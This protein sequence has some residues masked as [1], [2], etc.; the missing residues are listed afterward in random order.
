MKKELLTT[1]ALLCGMGGQMAFAQTDVTAQYLQNPGFEGTYEVQSNPSADRAIYQPEGWTVALENVDGYDMSILTTADLASDSF[2]AFTVNDEATRGNQTYW[3]RY[4]WGSNQTLKV[5][6][7]IANLPAGV[8]RLTADVLNYSADYNYTVMLYAGEHAQTRATISTEK[9]DNWS[10]LTCDFYVENDGTI[11]LGLSATNPSAAERIFAVD[12]F[13]LYKL[14]AEAPNA[15]N[16][17]SMTGYIVNPCFNAN[18]DGW[19]STTG[20]QNRGRATNKTNGIITGGFYENWNPNAYSGTIE[21]TINNLPN[22]KYT[23][24]LAAFRSGSA[25]G[26]EAY[27]FANDDMTLI[28]SDEG[29][30]YEVN[31]T[32]VDGTLTFGLKSVNGGC[33]WG[34]VD[35]A[36]LIYHG[37]DLTALVEKLAGVREAATTLKESESVM[38]S[39]C[40][41]ALEDALAATENVAEGE[42][43]LFTAISTVS[44]AIDAANTSIASNA[45]FA[46]GTVASDALTNWTY[47]ADNTFQV[48]TWSVEGNTD[49]SNMTTPFLQIWRSAGTNLT[50][51]SVFYTLEGMEPGLEYTATALVRVLNEGGMATTGLTMFANENKQVIEGGEACDK[52]FYNTYSVSGVVGEDGVLKFGFEIA[53]ATFNWIAFKDIKIAAKVVETVYDL[54]PTE[55]TPAPETSI[56]EL[57]EIV[58]TFPEKIADIVYD[59]LEEC[60]LRN[61]ITGEVYGLMPNTSFADLHQIGFFAFN[62]SYLPITETGTYVLTVPAGIFGDADCI[63]GNGGHGNS[64]LTYTF[65]VEAPV[66]PV[67]AT[68]LPA[69]GEVTSLEQFV[70]DFDRDVN[71]N[72]NCSETIDLVDSEGDVVA[73]ATGDDCE[74]DW[75]N[76]CRVTVKLNTSVVLPG[77]YTLVIPAE[78][79]ELGEQGNIYNDRMVY[80]YVVISGGGSGIDAVLAGNTVADV[81]TINGVLVLK[82]ADREALKTL[83]KGVY[84]INGK[85]V[86]MK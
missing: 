68:I 41:K 82:N 26:G 52:G 84:V 7:E 38:S 32:V 46:D 83:K 70:I 49:G 18:V 21:Q 24:K 13:K 20:A 61:L 19:T 71:V 42:T 16:P 47:T 45:I 55:V 73:S 64:K 39:L 35:N 25:E 72:W 2:A 58:F 15:E 36:S 10:T 22:G 17:V 81:Y 5:S 54:V 28:T 12:N 8:Y 59:K 3:F 75:D 66:E 65:Y 27:V 44:A 51:G 86:I 29:T 78:R 48:N 43:A 40:R 23:L 85:K 63:K 1:W 76:Y 60:T 50:D 37:V 57:S 4:R 31:T 6:Q 77:A 74:L 67:T 9:A 11:E 79:F 30:S 34:G 56:E 14:D 69:E 33:N 62:E 80:S 53:D